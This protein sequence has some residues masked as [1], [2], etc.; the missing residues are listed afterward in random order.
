MTPAIEHDELKLLVEVGMLAAT[1]GEITATKTI[2]AA[3][4]CVRPDSAASYAGPALAYLFRGRAADAL[5]YLQRGLRAVASEEQP[6]LQ[7]LL[8]LALQV[9]ARN[10]ES[11]QALRT[12]GDHPMAAALRAK[13]SPL[14]PG[15]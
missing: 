1:H 7:A 2:F 14:Q 4:E 12:A 9:D 15:L 13:A 8:G 3:I 10:A 11:L 5:E 6:P